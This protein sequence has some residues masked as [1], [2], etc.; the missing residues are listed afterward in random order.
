MQ[1]CMVSETFRCIRST[2]E[3]FDVVITISPPDTVPTQGELSEYVQCTISMGKLL[4]LRM[5]GGLNA[6]QSL[7]IALDYIRTVLKS[8]VADGGRVYWRDTDSPVDLNSPW[9]A[10]MPSIK[11]LDG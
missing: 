1:N 9:F 2:G 6:F 10:P 7:C 8:F 3:T 4:P 11:S 5:V